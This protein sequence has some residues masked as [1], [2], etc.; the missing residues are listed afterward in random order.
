MTLTGL[1]VVIPNPILMSHKPQQLL[2][3]GDSGDI[4]KAAA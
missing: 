4:Q 3:P 1:S 2:L